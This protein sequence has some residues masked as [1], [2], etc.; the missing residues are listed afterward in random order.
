MK[1]WYKYLL[2]LVV[3][4]GLVSCH[5]NTKDEHAITI[6]TSPG[7]YSQL[8]LD[9]VKPILEKQGY[10]IKAIDFSDL[11]L[12]DIALQEGQIDLNVDQ[13]TAYLNAFNRNKGGQL[14]ALV[15]LPTVP[16]A[17]YSV[18]Y[19]DLKAVKN[20]ST[21]AI[22]NDP[23]NAARAYRLLEKAGWITLKPK[24]N[25]GT[26]SKNDIATNPYQLKISEIDSSNIPRTLPDFDFA[27]VPGSRAYAAKLDPKQA[28]LHEHIVPAFELVLAIKNTN[29]N[30]PWVK[31]VEDAYQSDEFKQYM[32]THNINQYWYIP[33]NPPKN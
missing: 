15:H 2:V 21:V 27:V 28:L 32:D 18:H 11:M 29:L 22:P 6:G 14:I 10:K 20:G 23:S 9:A 17:I 4:I 13:H 12:A 1:T 31:A 19:P 5:Q 30:K 26:L 7:P 3:T 8:F 33:Q 16:T 25:D 24:N